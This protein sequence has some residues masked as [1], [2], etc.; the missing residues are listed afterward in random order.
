MPPR[1]VLQPSFKAFTG[2]FFYFLAFV[3]FE[4]TSN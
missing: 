4:G 3:V 1:V 2:M